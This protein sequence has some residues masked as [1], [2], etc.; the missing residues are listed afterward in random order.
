MFES[1]LSAQGLSDGE[2]RFGSLSA[3]VAG[4][5]VFVMAVVGVTAMIVP[6]VH[7]PPQIDPAPFVLV[8]RP[9]ELRLPQ[10]PTGGG[11]PKNGTSAPKPAPAVTPPAPLTPPI[12]TPDTSKSV[13]DTPAPEGPIASGEGLDGPSTGNGQGPGLGGDGD[14]GDSIGG[15]ADSG[16]VVLTGD[17][18]SPRRL[19]RVEP[20]YPDVARIARLSGRVVV[21][22]VIG[23][24]GN[25]ESAEIFA[26][27]STI[28]ERAALDAVLKWRYSPALMNG[29]PVRVYFTVVVDF[30]VR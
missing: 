6:P 28:F 12:T 2:R 13:V 4:H 14:G 22:A 23:L 19:V 7:P 29:R 5:L 21:K 9:P 26:S 3:A 20:V 16:P 10:P 25:V 1:T 30:S 27:T 17:M 15:G 11:T 24:D 8:L 18:V